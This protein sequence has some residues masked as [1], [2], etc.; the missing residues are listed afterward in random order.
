MKR[1]YDA[2]VSAHRRESFG[3]LP[4]GTTTVERHTLA[5]PDGFGI[6]V[7][8]YGGIIQEVRAPD[9]DGRLANV[10]LG[11]PDLDR[12]L[13]ETYSRRMPFFGALIGRY[14][15]RIARGHL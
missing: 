4:D 13:D 11:Y 15:N 7:L 1:Q 8:T 2:D 9:R 10:T 3:L 5:G 12:Y 14:G 6:A